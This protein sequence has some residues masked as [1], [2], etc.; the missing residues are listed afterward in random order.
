MHCVG[1]TAE[2]E[3]NDDLLKL[4]LAVKSSTALHLLKNKGGGPDFASI[5]KLE[6]LC[7]R[8][9][10]FDQREAMEELLLDNRLDP[11]SRSTNS[12][13]TALHVAAENRSVGAVELLLSA[14]VNVCAID[15]EGQ[16]ALHRSAESMSGRC[17]SLLLDYD[18]VADAVD[19]KG[20]TV[21]H[22]AAD[23]GNV[24][25]LGVLLK[26]VENKD[27]ALALW[28]KE[29]FIPIFHAYVA[30]SSKALMLLLSHT[31][32][33][34]R[35]PDRSSL[36]HYT[37]Q[38]NSVEILRTLLEKRVQF[39]GRNKDGLT[40]LHLIQDDAEPGL[41]RLLTSAG[42]EPASVTST[43]ETPLHILV[44]SGVSV[45]TEVIELLATRDSVNMTTKDG[46]TALHYAVNIP[47]HGSGSLPY[48]ERKQ[49]VQTLVTKDA[50]LAARDSNGRTCLHLLLDQ[51][52]QAKQEPA[53][54]DI[55]D[56]ADM[57][58][59]G[60]GRVTDTDVLHESFQGY[61]PLT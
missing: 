25:A 32:H 38:M 6:D 56:L 45:D 31:N 34:P 24:E 5:E 11:N 28:S 20:C 9:A 54:D 26:R 51:F 19:D 10:K 53:K 30:P 60:M 36:A 8:A 52:R 46:F 23:L 41:V 3:S 47:T 16:T 35:V 55:D 58:T 2:G 18:A 59:Y 33:I 21:W 27:S 15:H 14:G 22:L 13:E 12:K 17:I 44:R 57:I 29:G 4:A 40:A 48:S 49:Y 37:V 50:D 42:V 43:G 61:R 7:R 39:D 1:D